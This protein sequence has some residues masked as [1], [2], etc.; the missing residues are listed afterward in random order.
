MGHGHGFETEA[1][2][3]LFAPESLPIYSIERQG[4][5]LSGAQ[6]KPFCGDRPKAFGQAGVHEEQT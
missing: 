6:S 4:M 1:K 5:P 3:P 2:E